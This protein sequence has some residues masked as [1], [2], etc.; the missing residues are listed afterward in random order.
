MTWNDEARMVTMVTDRLIYHRSA[1]ADES[2]ETPG[3][4]LLFD[5]HA[6]PLGER[7]LSASEAGEMAAFRR[8]ADAYLN[9]YPRVVLGG[10]SGLPPP[11]Q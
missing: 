11:G 6:D 9:Q 1:P 3:G 10:R 2:A 7:D 4:E 5:P 8:L